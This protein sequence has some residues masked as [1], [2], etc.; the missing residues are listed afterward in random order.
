M[1]IKI[2]RTDTPAEIERLVNE[3][4]ASDRI[5]VDDIKFSESIASGQFMLTACIIYKELPATRTV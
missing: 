2:F 1:K 3:F 4:I 5:R